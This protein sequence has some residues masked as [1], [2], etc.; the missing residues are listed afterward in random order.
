MCGDSSFGL[1]SKYSLALQALSLAVEYG[2]DNDGMV[3]VSSCMLPGKRYTGKYSDSFYIAKI[4][5]ADGP[6]RNGNGDFG[7]ASRQPASWYAS[8]GQDLAAHPL[9]GNVSLVV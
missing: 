2:E 4:N 9:R 6:C 8:I 5:H 7:I 3:A 1:N